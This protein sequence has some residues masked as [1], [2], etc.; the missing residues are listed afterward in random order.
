[1]S[2]RST[3]AVTN[4]LSQTVFCI[5]WYIKSNSVKKNQTHILVLVLTLLGSGLSGNRWA[6]SRKQSGAGLPCL[7]SGSSPLRTQWWKRE[8]K[9]LCLLVF[10]SKLCVCE[11]VAVA[12]GILC[13]YRCLTRRSAPANKTQKNLVT[14]KSL[15]FPINMV[16]HMVTYQKLNFQM[17]TWKNMSV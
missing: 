3:L 11:P 4:P 1:M 6:A 12:I 5:I 7:H 9:S 2:F 17:N 16:I 10:S 13:L 8:N 15:D 14:H